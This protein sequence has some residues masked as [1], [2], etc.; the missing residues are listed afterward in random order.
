MMIL[1]YRLFVKSLIEDGHEGFA[2]NQGI[3]T[4]RKSQQSGEH[5]AI[6]NFICDFMAMFRDVYP[7]Y[8]GKKYTASA[9]R[10][11]ENDRY[12]LKIVMLGKDGK[13]ESMLRFCE[14]VEKPQRK[15]TSSGK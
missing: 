13:P 7:K 6:R 12:Y 2:F 11:L 15:K 9:E 8:K 10:D 4:I 3:K 5:E 14:V 1:D